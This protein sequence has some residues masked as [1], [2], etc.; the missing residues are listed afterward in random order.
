MTDAWRP[1]RDHSL[2]RGL[3]GMF[4]LT[5]PPFIATIIA[6]YISRH[7]PPSLRTP[8]NPWA[9]P[10][11]IGFTLGIGAMLVVDRLMHTWL[12]EWAVCYD[13][14]LATLDYPLREGES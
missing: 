10:L 8:E 7:V 2:F 14:W 1:L 4:G 12:A 5:S 11:L 6:V 13:T 9:M 3:V